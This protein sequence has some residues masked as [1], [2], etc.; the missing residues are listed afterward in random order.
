[1]KNSLIVMPEKP[2]VDLPEPDALADI[3]PTDPVLL[4]QFMTQLTKL[5][6]ELLDAEQYKERLSK[7]VQEAKND[8]RELSLFAQTLDQHS[9]SVVLHPLFQAFLALYIIYT[10][11][12]GIMAWT[13]PE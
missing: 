1:M 10:M 5:K 7:E 9:K 13:Q 4:L 3:K 2:V 8:I 12:Q 11:S 6:Q